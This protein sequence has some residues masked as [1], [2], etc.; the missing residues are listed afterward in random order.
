M[1]EREAARRGGWPLCLSFGGATSE[2]A[3]PVLAGSG[4]LHP[5]HQACAKSPRM[6]KRPVPS[7]NELASN[8]HS[9]RSGSWLRRRVRK[10]PG[11]VHGRQTRTPAQ[12]AWNAANESL[13]AGLPRHETESR[14]R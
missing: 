10:P 9:C 12:A 5:F 3:R 7:T 8:L 4:L 2:V 6:I 11:R 13:L 14:A 1:E